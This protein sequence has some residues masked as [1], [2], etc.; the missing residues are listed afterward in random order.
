MDLKI[1]APVEK[2]IFSQ[3]IVDTKKVMELIDGANDYHTLYEV[4]DSQ[5]EGSDSSDKINKQIYKAHNL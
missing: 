2:S 3:T 1:Y 4:I 5:L